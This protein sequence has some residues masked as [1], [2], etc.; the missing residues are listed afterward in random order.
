MLPCPLGNGNKYKMSVQVF[1]SGVLNASVTFVVCDDGEIYFKA[2]DVAEALGYENPREAIRM[3]VW[4]KNKFEWG[5][6]PLQ[7][8]EERISPLHPHTV[9]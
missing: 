9:F 2:K 5:Q 4:G 3:H 6:L 8:G 1:E 7:G